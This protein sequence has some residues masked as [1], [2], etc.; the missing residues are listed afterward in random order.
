MHAQDLFAPL[1]I[2]IADGDLAI[3]AARPQQ[4]R[5]EDVGAVGGRHD[6]DAVGSGEA[7]HLDEQLV[8]RLLALFMAERVAAA[9]ASDGIELVDEDDARLVTASLA[10][11]LAD[12]RGADAGIHFDEL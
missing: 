4:R 9:I 6:H 2:G 3:E 10:K 5:I 12:A 7:V 11:Q 8:E 1:Q